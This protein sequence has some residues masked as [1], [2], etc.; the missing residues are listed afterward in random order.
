MT[1]HAA[2]FQAGGALPAS[3]PEVEYRLSAQYRRPALPK[4]VVMA[5][6]AVVCALTPLTVLDAGVAVFGALAVYFGV[7]YVWRGRFRTRVTSR[8][9]EVRG[10]FNHFVPWEQVRD[11]EVTGFGSDRMGLDPDFSDSAPYVSA[12][13]RGLARA[14]LP[15]KGSEMSRLASIAVV[16]ADGHKVRLRAPLVS[17]WAPDPDFEDKARQLEQLCVRYGRG[18]IG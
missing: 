9:I 5:V 6:L 7:S 17:G 16:R 4:F 15:A 10:Y 11:I 13:I 18:A 1:G 8:G 3:G 12:S 14:S 2:G